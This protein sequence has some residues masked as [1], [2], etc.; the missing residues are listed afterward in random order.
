MSRGRHRFS[1]PAHR[2]LAPS[3]LAICAFSCAA[4]ALF[5][6][7]GEAAV[8]RA[9]VVVA[10]VAAV[11]GA[12][13]LRVLDRV[14]SLKLKEAVGARIREELEHEEAVARLE[15]EQ[16]AE[17]TE[18]RDIRKAV[19]QRLRTAT[20]ELERMRSEH[21]ALLR[22]YATAET[23]RA[24]VLESRRLLE[25]ETRKQP[26][27][28]PAASADR[29]PTGAPTPAAYLRASVALSSLAGRAAEGERGRAGEDFDYFGSGRAHGPA[30]SAPHLPAAQGGRPLPGTPWSTPNPPAPGTL[31]PPARPEGAGPADGDPPVVSAAVQRRPQGAISRV[32]DLA[33]S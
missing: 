20:A 27:A 7:D 26:I 9:L 17:L 12:S 23:E 25:L 14:A 16:E 3:L 5:V 4:A 18:S 2:L 30:Q 19:E 24:G 28:L 11:A 13:L 15:A 21:A 32:I 8:L 10:A 33:V 31:V 1:S 6:R 22:R 29:F